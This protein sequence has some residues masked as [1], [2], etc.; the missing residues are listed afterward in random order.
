[1]ILELHKPVI[2]TKLTTEAIEKVEAILEKYFGFE[3][4]SIHIGGVN[5]V[6]VLKLVSPKI[7]NKFGVGNG[8]GIS[9]AFTAKMDVIS[10]VK[11]LASMPSEYLRRDRG[12]VEWSG[13]IQPI[14][15]I[16][17]SNGL[18]L[19]RNITGAQVLSVIL[20]EIGHSFYHGTIQSRTL[21]AIASVLATALSALTIIQNTVTRAFIS[22]A[23]SNFITGVIFNVV[24]SVVQTVIGE[25]Y[26]LLLGGRLTSRATQYLGVIGQLINVAGGAYKSAMSFVKV[27]KLFEAISSGTYNIKMLVGKG[28]GNFLKMDMLGEEKFADEFAAIHGYGPELIETLSIMQGTSPWER[29]EEGVGLDQILNFTSAMIDTLRDEF[30]PHPDIGGRPVFLI[31]FYKGQLQK[32]TNPRERKYIEEQIVKTI[33]ASSIYK[34]TPK[35]AKPVQLERMKTSSTFKLLATSSINDFIKDFLTFDTGSANNL[36]DK[37]TDAGK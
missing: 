32:V 4:L 3:F 36:D 12:R 31:D 34:L 10:S 35:A 21:T 7:T 33:K 23:T 29:D 22:V 16:Y 24:Y 2:N 25:M 14:S 19:Q 5:I 18:L 28:V 11:Y 37:L 27:V 1:M 30:D 26:S 17:I 9:N 13:D 6:D 8:L 20:H 15:T